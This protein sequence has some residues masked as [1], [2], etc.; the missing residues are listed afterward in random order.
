MG[1]AAALDM[2]GSPGVEGVML[3]DADARRTR[4]VAARHKKI[5]PA[6]LDVTD[7]EAVR[8]LMRQVDG[9]LSAV[10]YFYNL[11]LSRAAIEAGCHFCDLGGNSRLVE[12]QFRLHAAARRAGVRVLPDCGLSPGLTSIL[13]AD[14][15]SRLK[16]VDRIHIRV[17]GLPENPQP[18]LNYKLLFS[19][20]GLLNEYI[21]TARIIRKGR[22]VQVDSM[23]GIEEIR[24]RGFPPLE[25][26]YTSGGASTLPETYGGQV[27]ELDEKTIRYPGHCEAFRLLFWL[28]FGAGERRQVLTRALEKKLA[29]PGGDVLLLRVDVF[30]RA[31]GV[32]YELVER[33]TETLTAMMKTTAWP[34][35]ILLQMLVNGA[36]S[37]MGVLRLEQAVPT[38]VF[39]K[40]FARRGI[41]LTRRALP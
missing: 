33:G 23:T 13:V 22:P 41:R 19:P 28:G 16:R 8:R 17:G 18:P 5:Q 15:V 11:D 14:G 26:F 32:R 35:S 30:G 10:P 21:E 39:L 34:A 3:A 38:D 12:K 25:A 4:T 2:A 29:L 7:G 27:R 1:S 24:F 31:G 9:T 36:V 20:H 6:R 37:E 40:E